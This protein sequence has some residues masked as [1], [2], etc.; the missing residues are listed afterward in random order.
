MNIQSGG[1]TFVFNSNGYWRDERLGSTTY[2]RQLIISERAAT[3]VPPERLTEKEFT[4]AQAM[5][6][7]H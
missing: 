7:A 5:S 2:Y 4:T 1:Y 6:Q 3:D